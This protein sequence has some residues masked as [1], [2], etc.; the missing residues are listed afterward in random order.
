MGLLHP[1][2][3]VNHTHFEPTLPA[4]L[5]A[6]LNGAHL[7]ASSTPRPQSDGGPAHAMSVRT[8]IALEV[9]RT[10]LA[11]MGTVPCESLPVDSLARFAYRAADALV[12][13]A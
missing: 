4:T 5:V 13:E 12:R 3:T 10:R 1:G 11:S 7:W 2:D 8:A 9:F 6:P